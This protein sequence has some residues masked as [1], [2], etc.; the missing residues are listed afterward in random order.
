[1]HTVE[2][3]DKICGENSCENERSDSFGERFKK[4]DEIN[5]RKERIEYKESDY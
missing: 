5:Y 1:M 2:A 3:Y 4:D